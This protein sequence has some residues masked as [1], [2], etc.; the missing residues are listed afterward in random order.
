MRLVHRCSLGFSSFSANLQLAQATLAAIKAVKHET[1]Q[2]YVEIGGGAK[3]LDQGDRTGVGFAVFE[4]RL[5]D[6]KPR[7]IVSK[8]S[9]KKNSSPSRGGLRWGWAKR[10]SI[11]VQHFLATISAIPL[12]RWSMH[13][14]SCALPYGL[15]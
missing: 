11:V 9:A 10:K 2:M 4:S 5:F 14:S 6:Q 12:L 8:G 15:R 3:A 1:M 13:E 7:A